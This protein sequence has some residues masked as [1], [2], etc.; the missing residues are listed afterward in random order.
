MYV[1]LSLSLSLYDYI[2]QT[3]HT[4]MH[5][6]LQFLSQSSTTKRQ[7]HPR[8]FHQKNVQTWTGLSFSLILR[9]HNSRLSR[10]VTLMTHIPQT[11]E[12]ETENRKK[13]KKAREQTNKQDCVDDRKGIYS[14]II[15]IGLL[16]FNYIYSHSLQTTS[17]SLLGNQQRLFC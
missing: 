10:S 1:S 7:K 12:K 15:F 5:L 17:V 4:Q 3:R 14:N 2:G 13:K 6:P 8:Y 16:R 9:V 11:K